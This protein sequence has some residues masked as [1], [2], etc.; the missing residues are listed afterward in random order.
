MGRLEPAGDGCVLLGSTSNPR[1]YAEEWLPRV[2]CGF[3][4]EG[5]PELRS[6]M[7]A[8]AARLAASVE[9]EPPR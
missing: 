4:V 8:L 6:A 1:M 5:G 2:P 9:D 3:R 7:A